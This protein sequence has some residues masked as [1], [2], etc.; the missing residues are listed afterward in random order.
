M[1]STE[2]AKIFR[3]S[4]ENALKSLLCHKLDLDDPKSLL[5]FYKNAQKAKII[6][7][8][9]LKAFSDECD[10][11]RKIKTINVNIPK[12]TP[13]N[14]IPSD[15]QMDFVIES[16][17][18]AYLAALFIKNFDNFLNKI[19]NGEFPQIDYKK[20]TIKHHEDS[21]YKNQPGWTWEE[22]VHHMILNC[23]ET[24]D[25]SCLPVHRDDYVLEWNAPGYDRDG[26][27]HKTGFASKFA[28]PSFAYLP[29]SITEI[30]K[31]LWSDSEVPCDLYA[32][33]KH[34]F[35]ANMCY[36]GEKGENG[37]STHIHPQVWDLFERDYN[38]YWPKLPANEIGWNHRKNVESIKLELIKPPQK[39]G[40]DDEL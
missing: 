13:K 7:Q 14:T 5:T 34:V 17:R 9:E 22:D 28:K 6:Y 33:F 2:I 20:E 15:I 36:G 19:K 26:V 4:Q 18:K 8:K 40:V 12:L 16:L 21:K 37:Y 29:K 39:P 3:S 32:D 23:D 31:H 24:I 38:D 10:K 27:W 30:T 1:K 35:M 25:E 11:I